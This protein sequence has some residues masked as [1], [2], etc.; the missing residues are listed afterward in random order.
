MEIPSAR[1]FRGAHA[2]RIPLK[3]T[4]TALRRLS[5]MSGLPVMQGTV[6]QQ[7]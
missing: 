7:T 5:G 2:L 6:L 3:G 1:Q 4:N